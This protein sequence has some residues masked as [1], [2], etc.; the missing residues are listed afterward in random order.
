MLTKTN[1]RN[2]KKI[3]SLLALLAMFAFAA[4]EENIPDDA[5]ISLNKENVVFAP[6]GGS[7]DIKVYSNYDWNISC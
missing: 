1:T 4:C 3:V 2:M 7:I 5:Y 6:D